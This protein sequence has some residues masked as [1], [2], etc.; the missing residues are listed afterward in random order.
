MEKSRMQKPQTQSKS[1]KKLHMKC[2]AR[3]ICPT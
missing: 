3:C 2:C 1:F